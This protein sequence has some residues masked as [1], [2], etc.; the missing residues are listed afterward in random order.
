MSALTTSRVFVLVETLVRV[1]QRPVPTGDIVAA[2]RA[3]PWAK[4]WRYQHI[5]T[6]LA[7]CRAQGLLQSALQRNALCG[8]G[9]RRMVHHWWPVAS[10]IGGEQQSHDTVVEM[11]R[12]VDQAI[13]GLP[14][15]AVLHPRWV[16]RHT[17]DVVAA[18]T[19]P[20]IIAAFHQR[21]SSQ[22]PRLEACGLDSGWAGWW[23]VADEDRARKRRGRR[24]ESDAVLAEVRAE[25]KRTGRRG[26]EV[27][28]L[29]RGLSPAR[30][31]TLTARLQV[32]CRKPPTPS[33]LIM[34]TPRLVRLGSVH[35]GAYVVPLGEEHLA[36]A[37]LA[38][39]AWWL[40]ATLLTRRYASETRARRLPGDEVTAR[41][42][43]APYAEI[44][45]ELAAAL[46]V[47][48]AGRAEPRPDGRA[49]W[50]AAAATWLARRAW[51]MSVADAVCADPVPPMQ[52]IS[53]PTLHR[54]MQRHLAASQVPSIRLLRFRL[55]YAGLWMRPTRLLPATP[56][57]HSQQHHAAPALTMVEA[58]DAYCW[59][60]SQVVTGVEREQ[61]R[62]TWRWLGLCRDWAAI[63]DAVAPEP[64][65]AWTPL[66][67]RALGLA[68]A[69]DAMFGF[70]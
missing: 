67:R 46:T 12:L 19:E 52:W 57:E 58:V 60:Q 41:G 30:A 23:R 62:W 7:H 21:D 69:A 50:T 3:A 42:R 65:A 44:V 28:T 49:P 36:R 64:T 14:D 33:M 11:S 35:Y 48:G 1:Q 56:L 38:V 31:R 27:R 17:H 40:A 43:H 5:Y 54:A 53:V 37:E 22:R 55:Q 59:L 24:E 32:A 61:H 39:E 26:V 2:V 18:C 68:A 4:P 10:K 9:R 25:Q 13:A 20:A 47:I 45:R 66:A 34:L 70:G 6:A 63:R 15:G 51:G 8:R 16:V 29:R